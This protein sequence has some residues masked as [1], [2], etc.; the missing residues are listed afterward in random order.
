MIHSIDIATNF[1]RRGLKSAG[2]EKHGPFLPGVCESGEQYYAFK[3][4][5]SVHGEQPSTEAT[6]V[7]FE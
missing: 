6:H 2:D 5:Y 3:V 4:S 7:E 1:A